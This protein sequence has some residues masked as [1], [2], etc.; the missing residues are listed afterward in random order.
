MEEYTTRCCCQ[1][2]IEKPLT[3]FYRNKNNPLG[4]S[5]RCKVCAYTPRERKPIVR[6]PTPVEQRCL[7]C[8]MIKPLAD[9]KPDKRRVS[10]ASSYC[11]KCHYL[12]YHKPAPLP[13]KPYHP[14]RA[15]LQPGEEKLC[16]GCRQTKSVEEF[17]QSKK[18]RSGYVTYCKACEHA[19]AKKWKQ[20]NR[21]QIIAYEERN[22]EHLDEIRRDWAVRNA[23][24]VR[25]RQRINSKT[26]RA[27][28]RVRLR[29][30]QR[31][32]GKG[33][34]VTP[35]QIE[36]LE[37]R[38]KRC[39]YCKKPFNSKRKSTLDHVIP[40]ARGGLHDISNIV[41]ACWPCNNKKSAKIVRLL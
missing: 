40:L 19:R 18:D 25:A 23:D 28:L 10:G 3:E 37:H 24:R 26:P 5:Y 30:H 7:I 27:K 38:Q 11:R 39:Y 21:D 35:A 4:R 17:R 16:T 12:R 15:R 9:F 6:A 41:L 32:V 31:R 13:H 34:P 8:D 20:E 29:M 1:C 36:E 33:A 22:K 2:G 14:P